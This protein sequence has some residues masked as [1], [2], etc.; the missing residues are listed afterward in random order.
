[1]DNRSLIILCLSICL[2][3]CANEKEE[4]T[5]PVIES[6]YSDELINKLSIQTKFLQ[7]ELSYSYSQFD[8][9]NVQ[10]VAGNRV[11][12]DQDEL[13]IENIFSLQEK[14]WELRTS[15]TQ[16]LIYPFDSSEEF[17]V[18][19][20]DYHTFIIELLDKF[21]ENPEG[22]TIIE[23]LEARFAMVS[24]KNL[25]AMEQNQFLIEKEFILQIL[26]EI[27]HLSL[28]ELKWQLGLG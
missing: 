8:Q 23:D 17:T 13:I 25:G 21:K 2:I 16:N 24:F 26:I 7:E 22:N 27:E 4:I 28:E 11:K 1:M 15:I 12:T 20:S 5:C 19:L 3:S 6:N 14:S 9:I 18:L 10:F